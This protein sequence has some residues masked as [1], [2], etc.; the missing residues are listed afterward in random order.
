MNDNLTESNDTHPKFLLANLFNSF[1]LLFTFLNIGANYAGSPLVKYF[2]LFQFIALLVLCFIDPIDKILWP[3]LIIS[4]FEGQGRVVWGYNPLFRLGFDILLALVALRGMIQTKNFFGKELLP[5]SIRLF[6]ILHVMW[7]ALELFNSNGAG[8]FPS[9]ATSKI[10]IFP[11]L[12]FFLFLNFPPQFQKREVQRNILLF[13]FICSL[14][15]GL[16]I[17][18]NI[19]R[20][21]FMEQISFNYKSLFPSYERFRGLT[22]RPWGT[23][24]APGG[25]GIF[26]FLAYGFVFLL[27]PNVISNKMIGRVSIRLLLVTGTLL[28]LFSSFIGQVRSATMKLVIVVGFFY[29]FQFMSSKVKA[30]WVILGTFG[31]LTLF[32]LGSTSIMNYLP[33]D[34]DISMAISRWEGIANSDVSSHRAGFD[35]VLNNLEVRGEMPFGYGLGM[36]Q[37]FL[38]AFALRRAQYLDRPDWYF[39]SMDNLFAFLVLELGVGA[40]FYIF[41]LLAVN[42]GLLSMTII[43]LRKQ[44]YESF[45]IV[46]LSFTIIFTITIFSWGAVSIPFNPVSFFFWLWSAIGISQFIRSERSSKVVKSSV[47]S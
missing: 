9:L 11:L 12:I 46:S 8:I 37:G 27:R 30:K 20:D 10:Y 47:N 25:M 23:T 24:F 35:E 2:Y 22:F 17:V 31:M 26:Y 19:F 32:S 28:I 6:F 38:P 3:L 21:P 15:A 34:L 41:L 4:L 13:F 29:L 5:G 39:W 7:F 40:I 14:L 42:I 36:T 18:Q 16:T 43:L 1:F 44:K 45:R 33:A